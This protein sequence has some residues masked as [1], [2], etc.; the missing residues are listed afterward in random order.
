MAVLEIRDLRVEF[1]T[2]SGVVKALDGVNLTLEEGEVLG[3]VGETGCGKSVTAQTILK[4]LPSPPAKI[5]G[6]EILLEGRNILDLSEE[7]LG[8]IRGRK[9]TMIF[10]EPMTSLNPVFTVWEQM[11][12][13]ITLHRGVSKEEA[14]KIAIEVLKDVRMPDPEGALKKYPH[15]LSGGQRQRIMIAMALSCRPKILIADE[16][17]TALDVT[18]QAQILNL[19]KSLQ[20]KYGMSVILI[21][22]DMG[23]VAQVADRVAVMYAGSVVEIGNV[24]DV[25]RNPLHPYTKGLLKAIPTVRRKMERLESIPGSVPN[26]LDPPSGCRFHPRCSLVKDVCRKVKPKLKDVDG[27]LVACHAVREGWS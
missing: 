9:I 4:L 24:E 16:P 5:T 6:G 17:T 10:Q 19:L 13:V 26:L 14:W 12:D 3:V 11:K 22:H 20:E 27:R 1:H 15:E 7:E 23:V 2:E 18:I 8:K 21:T 25:L